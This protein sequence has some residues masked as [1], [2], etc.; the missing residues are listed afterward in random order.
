MSAA[1]GLTTSERELRARLAAHTKWA[2][3]DPVEGT[4]RARATFLASF[5]DEVDPERK[6]PEGERLRRAENARSAHF[7]RL[8]YLSAKAR[9]REKA[10]KNATNA[11]TGTRRSPTTRSCTSDVSQD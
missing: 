9:R 11:G 1:E 5:L 8:A 7:T 2:H 4:A 10:A 3:T 6:L